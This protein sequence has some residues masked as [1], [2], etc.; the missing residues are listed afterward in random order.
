MQTIDDFKN[1]NRKSA[2]PQKGQHQSHGRLR[3]SHDRRR[4]QSRGAVLQ[5][6]EMDAVDQG[7]RD[8]HGAQ[9]QI[10]G[11]MFLT[12][13]GNEKEP[14]GQRII[15]VPDNAEATETCAIRVPASLPTC[16]T[17]SIKKGEALVTTGGT[18]RRF[19][20]PPAM[21]RIC[22]AWV[23]CRESP[24][25][26]RAIWRASSTTCRTASHGVWTELMK[27]VVAKLTPDDMIAIRGLR[28]FASRGFLFRVHW[29]AVGRHTVAPAQI[30]SLPAKLAS[31]RMAASIATA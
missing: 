30:S 5:L 21:A 16:P 24:A 23:R 9:D 3:Q 11:G 6:D 29:H 12:L 31:L 19:S 18:A 8:Q 1:G 13:E 22:K 14:I 17:G 2:D 27:P 28:L 26:R 10:D 15:E 7:R 4:N 20:A 25:A